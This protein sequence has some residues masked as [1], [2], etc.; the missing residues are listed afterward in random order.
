MSAK[1]TYAVSLYKELAGKLGPRDAY[2]IAIKL[3]GLRTA[4]DRA[5]MRAAISAGQVQPAP[6]LPPRRRR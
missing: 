2:E 6:R 3:A 4:A 1:V 5:H